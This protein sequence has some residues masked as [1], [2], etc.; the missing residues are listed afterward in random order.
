[1]LLRG[2]TTE[3]Y[4]HECLPFLFVALHSTVFGISI[5]HKSHKPHPSQM[6]FTRLIIRLEKWKVVGRL[7]KDS[8]ALFAAI[9]YQV[10]ICH[11]AVC[12]DVF[13]ALTPIGDA[14]QAMGEGKSGP[15]ETRL[16]QLVATTIY[17]HLL[18]VCSLRLHWGSCQASWWDQYWWGTCGGVQEQYLGH[19]VWWSVEHSWCCC[20]VQTA[21]ILQTQWVCMVQ[22][23]FHLWTKPKKVTLE[24]RRLLLNQWT[25]GAAL[26]VALYTCGAIL[27]F[28]C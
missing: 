2:Q 9:S 16:M 17:M 21:R 4:M 18:Y 5:I 27:L 6:K 26:C 7:L 11:H 1:M 25:T 15:V 22:Y 28:L 14:K 8:F 20:G 23:I 24:L 19:R 10:S 3:F 13:W 12:M